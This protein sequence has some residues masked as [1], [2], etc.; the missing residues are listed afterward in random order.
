MISAVKKAKA[1]E[2]LETDDAP[3]VESFDSEAALNEYLADFPDKGVYQLVEREK[4]PGV[5][6]RIGRFTPEE[7]P[8]DDIGSRY[9]GG[10]YRVTIKEAGTGHFLKR[11]QIEFDDRLTP[12]AAKPADLSPEK[13]ESVLLLELLRQQREDAKNFQTLF[14]GLIEKLT[15]TGRSDMSKEI[16][17]AL[18]Q[19]ALKGS[20]TKLAE[21]VDVFKL[22][23]DIAQERAE[24]GGGDL[25][26]KVVMNIVGK[27]MNGGLK[28]PAMG[29]PAQP[30]AKE[31]VPLNVVGSKTEEPNIVVEMVAQYAPMIMSAA[32]KDS[33]PSLY[34]EMIYDQVPERHLPA[35]V[36]FLEAPDW[37]DILARSFPPAAERKP[38]FE[39]LRN[40][41]L[42]IAQEQRRAAE[43]VITD[44]ANEKTT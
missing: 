33:D 24:G 38:W 21:L 1:T 29:A 10:K 20:D 8:L 34:A 27:F 6:V 16:E 42:G 9:G 35:I 30:P 13:N 32:R 25:I 15:A 4:S 23:R 31:R 17:T 19:K 18:I 39:L 28:L 41:I 22:G 43:P 11:G 5:F 7:L 40:E 14:L 12:A 3:K 26:E 37:F 2:A 36:A 44:V